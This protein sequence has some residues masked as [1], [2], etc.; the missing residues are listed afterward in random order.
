MKKQMIQ[1]W[2]EFLKCNLP[3]NKDDLSILPNEYPKSD[4]D[5]HFL[6]VK[7]T[8]N[9]TVQHFAITAPTLKL[10]AREA[11]NSFKQYA[12][13]INTLNT[14]ANKAKAKAKDKQ[15]H[16]PSYGISSSLSNHELNVLN[17][18]SLSLVTV[19]PEHFTAWNIRKRLILLDHIT[20]TEELAFLGLLISLH[21]KRYMLWTHRLYLL[22]SLCNLR[23]QTQSSNDDNLMNEFQLCTKAS[24]MYKR[25]YHAWT[26]RL[27][28]LKFAS[29]QVTY[30][31]LSKDSRLN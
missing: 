5:S 14:L 3:S 6:V 1:E 11:A 26:Y 23:A 2:C 10:L 16:S 17:H 24:D 27:R 30:Y 7:E 20:I 29:I 28:I 8:G 25:N 21:P 22:E 13:L 12:A 18:L 4:T 31:F 15:S 9:D 19:N